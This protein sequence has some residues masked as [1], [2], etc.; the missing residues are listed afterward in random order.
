M[1]EPSLRRVRFRRAALRDL[2]VLVRQR[3]GM[4]L[5]MGGQDRANLD[6]HDRTF[7]RWI[8]TRLRSGRVVG[9]VAETKGQEIVAGAIVWLRPSVPQPGGRGLVQPY[10]LSMYTEPGWRRLGLSSRIVG[11]AGKWAKNN[12][13]GGVRLH[14]S[15]M[16]RRLYLRQGFKRTW[17]MKLEL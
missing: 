16:G 5:S 7:R 10:L 12:G 2:D 8:R 13:Y 15:S 4:W 11:E 6:E 9:W 3:R 14:A 1:I 17:E